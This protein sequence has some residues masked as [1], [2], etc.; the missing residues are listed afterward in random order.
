MRKELKIEWKNR[1]MIKRLKSLKS[2][3][4][5]LANLRQRMKRVLT[6]S[7]VAMG[8]EKEHGG[9]HHQGGGHQ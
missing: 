6:G 1:G 9:E 5:M 4:D 7:G 3:L 8:G 2:W